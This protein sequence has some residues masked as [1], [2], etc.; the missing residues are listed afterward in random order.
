MYKA[1]VSFTREGITVQPGDE[2]T[3]ETFGPDVLLQELVDRGLVEASG[4]KKAP[5]E[6]KEPAQSKKKAGK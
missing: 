2:I 3:A 5:A 1:T 4:E 6:K